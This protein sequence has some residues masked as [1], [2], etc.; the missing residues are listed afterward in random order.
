MAEQSDTSEYSARG[1]PRA[2]PKSHRPTLVI[3]DPD[4]LI[5]HAEK[6]WKWAGLTSRAA[7]TLPISARSWMWSTESIRLHVRGSNVGQ[8]E[9]VQP[10]LR[11]VDVVPDVAEQL[12]LAR[13]SSALRAEHVADLQVDR[14]PVTAAAEGTAEEVLLALAADIKAE[15]MLVA[16]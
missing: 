2:R 7:A 6:P 8:P 15:G 11:Q 13:W 14:G 5:R 4:R 1:T 10:P 16:L 3:R 9:V 12:R